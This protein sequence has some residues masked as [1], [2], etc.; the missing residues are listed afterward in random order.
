MTIPV[1]SKVKVTDDA[2]AGA[3]A[4]AAA[5]ML[6]APFDVL[7]IRFQLQGTGEKKYKTMLQSFRTVIKEEGV[8]ALWKGNLS[9]TLLWVSYM[10]AQFTIYGILKRLGER[11]PNPFQSKSREDSLG[12][13]LNTG[14]NMRS[15]RVWKSLLLFLAGAGAGMTDTLM[16]T[17]VCFLL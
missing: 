4:G 5:R 12:E 13:N 15:D 11:T 9:A 2:V 3:F 10:A 1:V 14:S 8:L 16:D 17:I 7:K 6:T